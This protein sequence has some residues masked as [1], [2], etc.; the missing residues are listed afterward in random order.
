MFFVDESAMITTTLISSFHSKTF[1]PFCLQKKRL[2][3]TFL[4]ITVNYCKIIEKNKLCHP[5][6]QVNWLFY[7]MMLFSD[8]LF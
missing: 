6:Q 8:C 7:D 4:T 3:N 2:E 5:K 1:V